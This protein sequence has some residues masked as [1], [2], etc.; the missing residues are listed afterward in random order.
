MSARPFRWSAAWTRRAVQIAA[1]LLFLGLFLA[2]R[3]RP[4][5]AP[6]WTARLFVL[7]DPLA[8]VAT[9]L[10]AHAVPAALLLAL[11]TV[12][13]TAL[14]G[15]VFCGWVCPFGT[16]HAIAG[17]VLRWIR[18]AKKSS[19]AFSPWQR[20]KYYMLA[21][22]LV[23]A[24]FG[25][26]W[27]CVWD[28]IVLLT[29]S[30][31]AAFFPGAQWA[32]EDGSKAIYDADPGIGPLRVTRVT[33][34]PYRELRD[35]VLGIPKLSFIGGGALLAIVLGL[36]L[37][38]GVRRRFWCRYLCPL[39]ALLGL[40]AW[41]PALRRQVKKDACNQCD[42]CGM[43]CAGGAAAA[44]GE[45]WMSSECLGC[46]GC[47]EAC[48]RDGLAFAWSWPMKREP[49]GERLDL[50]KRALVASAA[51]GVIGLGLM[52]I[53][54]QARGSVFNPDLIRPPGALA[55]GDFLARCL[56]C[57]LCMK[58]C[59]TGGLQPAWAEAG[60]E[61]LWTPRLVPSIGYCDFTCTLCGQVCPTEAIRP[62]PLEEKQKVKIGL[63]RFDT[64]RCIPYAYGR[65]C[66]VCE[67][68][69]PLPKKAIYAVET[70]VTL[71]DG[72]RVTLKQ[73]RIDAN[74]CTGCGICENAC[75]FKDQPAVR[76]F[77][78]N[79]SRHPKTNQP[80]MPDSGRGADPY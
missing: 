45:R 4:G 77:S 6:D 2:V 56:A 12:V 51:G 49:A 22:F 48:R 73:P 29:R 41:R 59:P 24:A 55:E 18:P 67:E 25:G 78:A 31:A 53:T 11:V 9:L 46:L 54:P 7:L 74:L 35:N 19:Q 28:P 61:G 10:A 37:L 40:I 26:H 38:N 30:C 13:V 72:A 8:L 47:T 15:R 44:P 57:G 69:C 50:S 52:R 42:L 3:M 64:T 58:I 23:M 65:E 34:G 16:L 1:L 66:I 43:A 68:V 14:L 62:L 71:R 76:V 63:A 20:A 21:G 60:L 32:V 5:W 75:P 39:G 33:E 70:V 36:L 27:V 79:E 80:I 17:R